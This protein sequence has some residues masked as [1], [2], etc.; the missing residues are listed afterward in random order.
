LKKV[1]EFPIEECFIRAYKLRKAGTKTA[2]I[3]VAVP[4][5]VLSRLVRKTGLTL[6]EFIEQYRAVV[7][8]GGGDEIMYRF[9][10]IKKAEEIGVLG[11]V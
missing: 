5:E 10:K 11:S 7:Y 4:L 6:D 9:E 3:D 1:I 8:F 2:T